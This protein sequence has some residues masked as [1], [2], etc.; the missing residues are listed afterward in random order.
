MITSNQIKKELKEE[1]SKSDSEIESKMIV[2]EYNNRIKKL[3]VEGEEAYML[4]Y[5]VPYDPDD[6]CGCGK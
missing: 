4:A 5:V 2:A 1:L 6:D 3:E